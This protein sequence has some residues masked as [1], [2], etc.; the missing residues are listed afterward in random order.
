MFFAKSSH[1]S[2]MTSFIILIMEKRLGDILFGTFFGAWIGLAYS[3]SSMTF[4]MILLPGI[5][6]KV[7]LG[8]TLPEY[9]VLYAVIGGVMGLIVS[10]PSS[11]WM[12]I[13]LGGIAASFTISISSLFSSPGIS[14]DTIFRLFFSF[15]Y[16]FLPLAVILMPVGWLIRAGVNAQH[17]DPDRPELWARRYLI[18]T[19][20]TILV[21]ILG[22]FSIFDADQRAGF[23]SV[24]NLIQSARGITTVSE[25]PGSLQTVQGYV[26]GAVGPYDLAESGDV[27]N[28]MGP[29]PVGDELSIFLIVAEFDSGLRFACIFQGTKTIVPYCTNF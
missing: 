25:L 14:G 19:V 17:P 9:L 29:Q 23:R 6:L 16:I 7:P 15:A 8:E 21:I 24:N 5:P 20:L 27:E 2:N 4:N 28:F 3:I 18:P 26:Q 1:L 12:G 11:P 13:A 22:S 10:L